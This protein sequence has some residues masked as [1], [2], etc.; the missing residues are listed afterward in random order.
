MTDYSKMSD[1]EINTHVFK[2]LTG[3]K[4][5]GY[6]H[7]ADGRSVGNAS[8]SEYFWYDYCNDPADAWPIIEGN[9]IWLRKLCG[10]W[11]ATAF[12][13]T[14]PNDSVK[15]QHNK[16]LRAAMTAYLMMKEQG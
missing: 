11:Q 4:P 5:L 12:K 8:N 15:A 1:F 3:T 2:K 13:S 14:N 7:H 6:P 9:G 16:P 10:I